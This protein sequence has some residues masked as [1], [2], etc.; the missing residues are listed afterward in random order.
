MLVISD[1]KP[2]FK[3]ET[4]QKAKEAK[5]EGIKIVMVV[6]N[7]QLGK[8]DRKFMKALASG[9][10]DENV[11]MIPGVKTLKA[12]MDKWVVGKAMVI[13]EVHRLESSSVGDAYVQGNHD[14]FDRLWD[15]YQMLHREERAFRCLKTVLLMY[16]QIHTAYT[17]SETEYRL[18]YPKTT[19]SNKCQR[20][21]NEWLK[22]N[23]LRFN[24]HATM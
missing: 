13:E 7:D 16:R 6:L 3:F 2:S 15:D 14:S 24:S 20:R 22:R 18:R 4:W 10:E 12:E 1:G 19:F 9:P 23:K 17:A 11:I 5:G 21:L 8:E